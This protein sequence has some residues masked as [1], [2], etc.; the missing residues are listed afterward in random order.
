MATRDASDN[1]TKGK[2]DLPIVIRFGVDPTDKLS[3][4]PDQCFMF[5]GF[6]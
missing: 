6:K 2:E 5:K 1:S 4:R 3:L